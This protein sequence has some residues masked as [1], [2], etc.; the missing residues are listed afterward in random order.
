MSNTLAGLSRNIG[1][2]SGTERFP[3]LK[4]RNPGQASGTTPGRR[5]EGAPLRQVPAVERYLVRSAR[6]IKEFPWQK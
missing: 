4:P 1:A 5:Y 6:S 2:H 3:D